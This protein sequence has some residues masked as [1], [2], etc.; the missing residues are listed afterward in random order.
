MDNMNL[1]DIDYIS[2]NE[3]M[4]C[5]I[6]A[7]SHAS[8]KVSYTKPNGKEVIVLLS[9]KMKVKFQKADALEIPRDKP[10]IVEKPYSLFCPDGP[11]TGRAL[12]ISLNN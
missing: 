6:I 8:N 9:G 10:F 5:E 11:G 7:P 4:S 12:K 1:N 2:A 3:D